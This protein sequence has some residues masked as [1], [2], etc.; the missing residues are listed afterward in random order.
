M[1][2]ASLLAGLLLATTTLGARQTPQ[3]PQAPARTGTGLLLGR[4]LE[5]DST[6]PMAD[7]LVTLTGSSPGN[8]LKVYTDAEGRFLFTRLPE[9]EFSARATRAGYMGGLLG[10]KIP[11]GPAR[12]VA[13]AAGDR[14]GD[15]VIRLWKYSAIAGAVTDDTGAPV[16]GTEVRLLERVVVEGRRVLTANSARTAITDDRGAYRFSTVTPGEYI[17]LARSPEDLGQR[18]L[19]AIAMS[20]QAAVMTV[21]TRAA[22]AAQGGHIED[23]IGIDSSL[24]ILAPTFYPAAS[25][26]GEA[27]VLRIGTGQERTGIDIRATFVPS[28]R[29]AGTLLDDAGQPVAATQVRLVLGGDDMAVDIATG[30]A[31]G[32]GRFSMV[33]VP[34]GRYT[35]TASRVPRMQMGMARGAPQP[36]PAE[37]PVLPTDPA[38]STSLPVVAGDPSA[39]SLTL[40]MQRGGR[41]RGRIDYGNAAARPTPEQFRALQIALV[42]AGDAFPAPAG[43][44]R[45]ESDGTFSTAAVPPGRY[46]LRV[47]VPAAWRAR[48]AIVDGSDMLD[49]PVAIAGSDIDNVALV[50]TDTPDATIAGVVR[51]S[52]GAPDPDAIVV[53]LPVDEALIGERRLK[54]ARTTATGEYAVP[55]LPAG[56]YV[57]T[58]ITDEHLAA[59]LDRELM[60]QA[61]VRGT[62]VTIGDGERRTVDL[63]SAG[64]R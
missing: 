17:V 42:P 60:S 49:T 50:L 63:R 40:M 54:I 32:D 11:G 16:V 51:T 44:G 37:Q 3:P 26:P 27:E 35:L 58:S 14:R 9:G 25:T 8:P 29:V 39:E 48:S 5:G 21:A 18:A 62:R 52:N 55:R 34:S 53:V 61:S 20:D 7:V 10:Q 1:R 19:M 12:P 36:R 4:V 23:L 41:V 28:A 46:R 24:R 31:G 56:D 2:L 64:V 47:T 22:A 57:V 13:L 45:I 59:G 43:Q 30:R 33:T 38:L 15:L 6:R